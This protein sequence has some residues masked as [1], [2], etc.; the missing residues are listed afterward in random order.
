LPPKQDFLGLPIRVEEHFYETAGTLRRQ[1]ENRVAPPNGLADAA[2]PLRYA[3][4]E[5]IY[6]HLTA[7][8]EEMLTRD[9]LFDLL[10]RL[11]S[12]AQKSL[13]A[14]YASTPRMQIYIDRCWRKIVRD[15][16]NAKWHYILCLTQNPKHRRMI[17]LLTDSTPNGQNARFTVGRVVTIELHFNELLV[18]D[19]GIPF[20][21]ADTKASTN[22]LEGAIYLDGYFW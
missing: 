17:K 19:S 4:S 14:S 22:P 10:D 12:W 9:I 15:D 21:I 16:I 13:G 1:I 6:Q 3:Y 7:M 18:H 2:S 11:R 8:A 5:Q 20:G